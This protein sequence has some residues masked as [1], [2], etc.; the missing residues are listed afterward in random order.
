MKIKGE[1]QNG[2]GKPRNICERTFAFS[3]RI[4]ALCRTLSHRSSPDE[5][6][7]LAKQLFRSGTSIGANVE[8]AHGSQGKPD[9]VAKMSIA[10][11]EARETHYW[12]RLS[13]ASDM[14]PPAR[15]RDII[16]EAHQ[17]IAILTTI[18]KKCRENPGK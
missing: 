17:L 9:Y 8:E 1:K 3:L 2:D 7:L 15:L 16:D 5:N 13:A 18:V 10:C 11:K 14:L 12:L 4:V 6:R